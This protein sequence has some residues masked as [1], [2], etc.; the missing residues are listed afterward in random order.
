MSGWRDDARC[1]NTD[2]EMWRSQAL[3]AQA[4]PDAFFPPPGGT[5][6]NPARRICR[7]CPVQTECLE[8][9]LAKPQHEDDYGIWGGKSPRERRALR[10]ERGVA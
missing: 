8:A 5:G 9:A 4:D 1:L 10:A 3:C 6:G 2:P 7:E